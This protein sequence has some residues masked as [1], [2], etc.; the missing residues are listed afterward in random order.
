M[1]S[2]EKFCQRLR[3]EVAKVFDGVC[4]VELKSHDTGSGK[5]NMLVFNPGEAM[6]SPVLN[7][8]ALWA[9]GM[10]DINMLSKAI[11]QQIRKFLSNGTAKETAQFMEKYADWE[12][13]KTDILIRL[14]NTAQNEKELQEIP[15]RNFLDLAVAYYLPFH[16]S[17][18]D[19]WMKVTDQIMKAWKVTEED[20]HEAAA[21]N[22]A[23][24]TPKLTPL[25]QVVSHMEQC[26]GEQPAMIEIKDAS[27]DEFYV[28][29]ADDPDY[30][31]GMMLHPTAIEEYASAV[32]DDVVIIPASVDEVLI[33]PN[34]L[35]EHN[36]YERLKA[37]TA[38]GNAILADAEHE[39]LSNN[40][41]LYERMLGR[42]R[43]L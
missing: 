2:K 16:C 22:M 35:A 4:T 18:C 36:G 15:H 5:K 24:L 33:A 27:P 13:A 40:I 19:G 3:D 37:I 39:V 21:G 12:T 42:Y 25:R 29:L 1:E 11:E 28:L 23:K 41:Y 26:Q 30:S 20:L 32:L 6:A 8:D 14:M 34:A 38:G 31:A 43:I 9:T 17:D 10:T 7:L